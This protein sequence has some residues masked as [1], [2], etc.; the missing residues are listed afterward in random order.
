MSVLSARQL[1]Y[2]VTSVVVNSIA[3]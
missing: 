3:Y 2:M 1:F